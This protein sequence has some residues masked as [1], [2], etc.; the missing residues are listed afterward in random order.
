VS[1][2]LTESPSCLVLEEQDMALHMQRL[3][4]AAG[5]AVPAAAPV[6]EINPAHALLARFE[7]ESDEQ[8]AA[9][10]GVR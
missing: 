9:A 6:L 10:G 4:Q 5:H 7:A 1:Q 2:R 3:L 8:R